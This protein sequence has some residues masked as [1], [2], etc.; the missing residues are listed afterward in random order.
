M[1]GIAQIISFAIGPPDESAGKNSVWAM[2]GTL[3]ARGSRIVG[4]T[5]AFGF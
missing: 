1:W 4:A 5:L 3:N 2:G